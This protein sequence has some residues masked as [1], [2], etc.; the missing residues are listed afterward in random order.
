MVGCVGALDG[1]LDTLVDGG[2]IQGMTG[3]IK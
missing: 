3:V 1:W 2:Q